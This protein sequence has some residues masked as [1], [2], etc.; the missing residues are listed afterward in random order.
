MKNPNKAKRDSSLSQWFTPPSVIHNVL[1]YIHDYVEHPY[2]ERNSL[3]DPTCG[4]GAV[5]MALKEEGYCDVSGCE[6]DARVLEGVD[7]DALSIKNKAWEEG[8]EGDANVIF[9]NPPYERGQDREWLLRMMGLKKTIIMVHRLDM[10]ASKKLRDAM[11][12]VEYG[13]AATTI[14][15]RPK[16]DGPKAGSPM[17]NF[18]V[19]LFE[20]GYEGDVRLFI[21]LV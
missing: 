4:N 1:W 2:H 8:D 16:F 7:C 11:E 12:E 21:D 9:L 13:I 19:S 5:L 6:I 14:V 15:G 3:H 20:Y 10:L 17:S 18:A